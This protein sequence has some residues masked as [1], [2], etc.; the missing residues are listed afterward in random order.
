MFKALSQDGIP[1]GP[2]LLHAGSTPG[3]QSKMNSRDGIGYF[4][5]CQVLLKFLPQFPGKSKCQ[6]LRTDDKLTN[7]HSV[8]LEFSVGVRAFAIGLSQ[9]YS[10][11]SAHTSLRI[12]CAKIGP[13]ISPSPVVCR[14]KTFK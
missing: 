2:I 6:T 3:D 14:D 4:A 10:F 9:I 7:R 8:F 5:S 13:F 11:F 1:L 12:G